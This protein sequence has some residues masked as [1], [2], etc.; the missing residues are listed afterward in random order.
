MELS[1]LK[2]HRNGRREEEAPTAVILN[3]IQDPGILLRGI[4]RMRRWIPDRGLE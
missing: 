4:Y 1:E 2:N 3:L